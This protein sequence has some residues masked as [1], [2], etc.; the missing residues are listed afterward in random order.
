MVTIVFVD[1]VLDGIIISKVQAAR[2]HLHCSCS[3]TQ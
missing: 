1:C 3:G 2:Y